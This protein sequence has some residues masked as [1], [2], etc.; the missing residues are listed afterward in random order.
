MNTTDGHRPEPWF[1]ECEPSECPNGPE[2]DDT[3]DEW[4]AWSNRH[5]WSPQDARVCLDTPAGDACA[6]CSEDHGEFVPWSACRI[7]PRRKDKPMPERPAHQP[8]TVQVGGLAC[9]ERE[10]DDYVTDDGN[11]VPN[12]DTC[13]HLR[14][15]EICPACT[16]ANGRPED[17]PSVVAWTD[18]PHNTTAPA[19]VAAGATQDPA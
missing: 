1:W 6:E 16:A 4:D 13:T 3:T 7:R 9:V 11:E 12:L 14:E 19:A 5:V 17:L 18:C 8:E 2:P 10:C 15:M